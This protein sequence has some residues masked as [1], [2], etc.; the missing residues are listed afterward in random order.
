MKRPV[1]LTVAAIVVLSSCSAGPSTSSST[2]PP[3]PS[4]IATLQLAGLELTP[5]FSPEQLDY[6]I[7]CEG[8]PPS[9]VTAVAQTATDQVTLSLASPVAF[10]S[11]TRLDVVVSR[12]GAPLSE[13]SVRCLPSDFPSVSVERASI[14]KN[15]LLTS[16]VAAGG[17]NTFSVLLDP[18]GVPVW[19]TRNPGTHQPTL[20][21]TVAGRFLRTVIPDNDL[22]AFSVVSGSEI[23]EEDFTGNVLRTWK[24]PSELFVDHHDAVALPNG[25]LLVTSYVVDTKVSLT[26]APIA[27]APPG[28]SQPGCTTGPPDKSDKPVVS[29][30]LEINP[31]GEVVSEIRLNDIVANAAINF[32]LRVNMEVDPAKPA[33]CGY[34]MFHMNAIDAVGTDKA[35]ISALALDGVLMVDRTTHKL[36]WRLGGADQPESLKI[37][38]DPLGD[39]KRVHDGRM[40]SADEVMLFDNRMLFPDDPARAVLYKIDE[41]ARTAT[42]VKQWTTSCSMTP[43]NSSWG[44]SARVSADGTVFVNTGGRKNGPSVEVF[45]QDGSSVARY[46]FGIAYRS[47]P[48]EDVG[49]SR[50]QLR[51]ATDKSGSVTAATSGGC[52]VEY[53]GSCTQ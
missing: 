41:K 25:N 18:A 8:S 29:R 7:R 13:Y 19:F 36:L 53:F 39:P 2:T 42:F 21:P 30:L 34:D 38:G 10:S 28:I 49:F 50:S 26:G 32:P 3:P 12:Q 5:S 11:M 15:W 17:K 45:L 24:T 1:W 37:L 48:L 44:G 20:Q 51:A 14:S 35:L 6:T 40:V 47:F 31:N 23:T 22:A 33:R 46:N 16:L 9:A 52:V 43:C 4:G 27:I